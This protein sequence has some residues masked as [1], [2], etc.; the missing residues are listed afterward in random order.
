MESAAFPPS[1]TLP[2]SPARPLRASHLQN[3]HAPQTLWPRKGGWGGREATYTVR[4]TA[5]RPLGMVRCHRIATGMKVVMK[6]RER[7]RD[8]FKSSWL[9]WKEVQFLITA[10]LFISNKTSHRCLHAYSFA[11]FLFKSNIRQIFW[12][13]PNVNSS[14]HQVS[15]ENLSQ[16]IG[17]FF[18]LILIL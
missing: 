13:W 14:L 18:L 6:R 16:R 7:K 15:G 1:I 8:S 4:E 11:T 10:K 12:H 9:I 17:F 5:T 2:G 3:H